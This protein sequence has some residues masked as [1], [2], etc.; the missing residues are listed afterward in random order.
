[1]PPQAD[2]DAAP[3][4]RFSLRTLMLATTLFACA[5]AYAGFVYRRLDEHGRPR[6]IIFCCVMGVV[7]LVGHWIRKDRLSWALGKAGKVAFT[8]PIRSH[9]HNHTE[10]QQTR[11]LIRLTA[12]AVLF[13]SIFLLEGL[14]GLLQIR[15]ISGS[16]FSPQTAKLID[17]TIL[18]AAIFG[19][20]WWTETLTDRHIQICEKGLIVGGHFVYWTN[21][22]E[23]KRK[24][25]KPNRRIISLT[26]GELFRAVLAVGPMLFTRSFYIP[27][28]QVTEV[29]AYITAHLTATREPESPI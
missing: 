18:I 25:P 13:F 22:K 15:D 6:F 28:D 1:M 26:K 12:I 8:L 17:A 27:E 3:F 5:A 21:V 4:R 19:F 24:A 7:V 11:A 20:V 23:I 29:D 9:K 10:A 14:V 2:P 16:F